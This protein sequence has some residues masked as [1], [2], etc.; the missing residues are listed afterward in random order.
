MIF[1]TVEYFVALK[2]EDVE[3]CTLTWK[4]VQHIFYEKK[5]SNERHV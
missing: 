3:V 1:A 2:I 4:D 5:A